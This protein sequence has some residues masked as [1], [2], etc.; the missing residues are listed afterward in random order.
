MQQ[1]SSHSHALQ[2]KRT[3]TAWFCDS[4]RASFLADQ[5]TFRCDMCDYDM[6][7]NCFAAY[8]IFIHPRHPHPL[9]P[10]NPVG[11]WRCDVC[12]TSSPG[13]SRYHCKQ[14]CDWDACSKCMTNIISH[15]ITQ[16]TI[17]SVPTTY[18]RPVMQPIP[19]LFPTTNLT[20]TQPVYVPVTMPYSCP[21]PTMPF[22]PPVNSL[23]PT[24]PSYTPMP[25]MSAIGPFAQ[26]AT[27]QATHDGFVASHPH[28]LVCMFNHN[29]WV[30]CLCKSPRTASQAS[31]RCVICSYDVCFGCFNANGI[32]NVTRHPHPL[33]PTPGFMWT[34]EVCK[35]FSASSRKFRCSM[36][37][38]YDV[39]ERCSQ[40]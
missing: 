38:N 37:C 14:G 36:G 32:R 9:T 39:C 34:C 7:H 12:S 28:S 33:W 40:L 3:S 26:P 10:L 24:L 22:Y 13:G 29:N 1:V 30:C 20:P 18:S 6:C 23:I 4:C 16:P 17:P 8:Q 15:S 5:M 19:P 31:Y 11:G 25:P 35:T 27:G 21:P 2:L